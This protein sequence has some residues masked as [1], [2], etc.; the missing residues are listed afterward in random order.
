MDRI[1]LRG[2]DTES[3]REFWHRTLLGARFTAIPRWTL[4]PV[5]GVSECQCKV[6]GEVAAALSRRADEL[7]VSPSSLWLAAHARVLGALSGRR[8]VSTGYVVGKRRSPL[9]CRVT[10]EPRS[11]LWLLVEAHRAEQELQLHADFPVEVVERE[12][13]LERPPFETVFDP[14]G[15]GGELVEHTALRVEMVQIKV[16]D[17]LVVR[18]TY[19]TDVLDASCA[20]RIAGYHLAALTS[21]ASDP[22]AEHAR[23]SLLT[24]EELDYQIHGLAGPRRQL[25]DRP[26]HQLFEAQVLAHPDAVAAI[27]GGWEWSYRHLNA[28]ANEVAS[29]LLAR[30]LR[31]EGVV[32]VGMQRSLDWLAAVL[33]IL[34][35]GGAYLPIESHYPAEHIVKMLR[36]AGCRRVMTESGAS[37]TLQRALGALPGVETLHVDGLNDTERHS[38]NLGVR[39]NTD[40]LAC[41]FFTSDPTGEPRGVM[42]EHA[43]M[44]N[45]LFAKIHDLGI[46]TGDVVAQTAPTDLDSSL[47]QLLAALLVGGRTLIVE[48]GAVRDPELFVDRI[49]TGRVD[50]FQVAPAQ[51]EGLVSYLTKHPRMLPDLRCVAVDGEALKKEL[52]QRWFEVE[53][54]TRL[55]STYGLTETSGGTHHEIVDRE[56]DGE[57]ITL[58][59]PIHNVRCYVV[60]EH[61]A[62]VPLGAP[63]EIVFSGV[64]V[65]RGYVNDERTQ[66]VFTADPHQPGERLYRSG[67]L[68]RWQP[69]GKLAFSSRQDGHAHVY[70][71]AEPA[72]DGRRS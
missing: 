4:E 31:P 12:L 71:S 3:S 63:G 47:W 15:S 24:R 25:P 6:P 40:Q 20:S 68:G 7:A 27:H 23:Q 36:R 35:A 67:D 66:L 22:D 8:E 2:L 41:I 16:R 30:G 69:G 48:P 1:G 53:P 50:V 56:P 5:A 49:A 39:V 43:G 37:V 45:H 34:K 29:A 64:C 51:L 28:R 13:G 33:G 18:L 42:C 46:A 19:R 72:A 26:A 10:I 58:G 32:A 17:T 70:G 60:D 55:V 14:T 38:T 65:G 57:P 59:R 61:L 9:L 54:A 52:V 21:I 11:W 44:V 62:P